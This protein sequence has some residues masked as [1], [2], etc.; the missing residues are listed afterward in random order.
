[1]RHAD[2]GKYEVVPAGGLGLVAVVRTQ[3]G[4]EV[5]RAGAAAAGARTSDHGQIGRHGAEPLLCAPRLERRLHDVADFVACEHQ[6]LLDLVLGEVEVAKAVVAHV[7]RA[8]AVQ[9]VVDEELRAM[10]ER[11]DIGHLFLREVIPRNAAFVGRCAHS[12]SKRQ[13]QGEEKL[14]HCVDSGRRI[15]ARRR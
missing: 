15:N 12:E 14:F 11:G 2:A 5:I 4:V 1:M 9:A 3:V 13:Q 6:V 8:V 7:G 10:L